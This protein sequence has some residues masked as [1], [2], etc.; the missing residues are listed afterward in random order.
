MHNMQ[1]GRKLLQEFLGAEVAHLIEN[2][3]NIPQQTLLNK[4]QLTESS[5]L[6]WANLL[7]P[8]HPFQ[9]YKV[10]LLHTANFT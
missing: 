6:I 9:H 10:N 4:C 1:D 2:L 7:K 8:I 3:S 5:Q